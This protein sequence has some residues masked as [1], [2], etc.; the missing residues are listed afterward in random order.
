[1]KIFNTTNP[2]RFL[3]LAG[4]M[5][6]CGCMANSAFYLEKAG[7]YRSWD[8]L[9]SAAENVDSNYSAETI[10]SIEILKDNKVIE[11][12]DEGSI[13][14]FFSTI[15]LS[16]IPGRFD[17]VTAWNVRAEGWQGEI[18]IR[19]VTHESAWPTGALP[20]AFGADRRSVNCPD[21]NKVYLVEKEFV[22]DIARALYVVENAK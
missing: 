5:G 20:A 19:Q 13:Y 9:Q 6:V 16:I 1:M 2:L 14:R 8:E 12:R 22:K 7:G 4:M 10:P 15:T 17:Y 11:R 21:N 18:R 3:A